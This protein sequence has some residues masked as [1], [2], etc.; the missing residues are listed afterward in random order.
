MSITLLV[1]HAGF[2]EP[3]DLSVQTSRSVHVN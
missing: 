3:G 2:A 1:Q